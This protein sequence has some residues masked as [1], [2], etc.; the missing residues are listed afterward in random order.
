[1][2]SGP[3]PPLKSTRLLD[4]L[5]E[6]VRY[7][8]YALA[9]ERS[10]VHWTSRFIFFHELRHPKDM[11]GAEVAE[12]LSHLANERGASASTH[13]QA[14]STLLFVYKRAPGSELPWMQEI[15]RPR[16]PVRLP[17]VLSQ[18]EIGRLLA[19]VDGVAGLALPLLYGTGMRKMECLRLRIKD[20]DFDRRLIVVREGKGNTTMIYT[21]VLNRGLRAVASPLHALPALGSDTGSPP[22]P[23]LQCREATVIYAARH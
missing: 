11:G 5:R 9:T 4:R 17:V 12:F 3:L 16:T 13:K 2:Q 14:L 22:P 6:R 10:Y 19:A 8:H 23:P 1:M 15:G 20:V 7:C 18:A 21:D